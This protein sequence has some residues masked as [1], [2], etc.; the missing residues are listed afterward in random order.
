[1]DR[2]R[3]EVADHLS[4]PVHAVGDMRAAINSGWTRTLDV[5]TPEED[6]IILAYPN[7]RNEELS[8]RL[9]GRTAT[10]V[11]NRRVKI[12]EQKRSLHTYNPYA[13]AGRPLLAK[14]CTKCGR[15]LPG[16]WFGFGVSH[17]IKCYSSHCR[18]CSNKRISKWGKEAKRHQDG[19]ARAYQ[20]KAQAITLPLA[21]MKG[22]P[23]TEADHR[24]LADP[25][26][27]LLAKALITR[28]TYA[29]TS[30]AAQKAGYKSYQPIGDPERDR[31]LIDNPNACRVDEITA[32]LKQE[33]ES[34]GVKFPEWDWDDE[35][36]NG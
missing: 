15:I 20:E 11:S 29:G 3:R 30:G 32:A 1:M 28:R 5:W 4:R 25:S 23:W 31:W 24:V 17:G 16:K 33:F 22:Q 9:P 18:E 2:P 13:V 36:L 21:E 12:Q 8:A 6:A 34:A 7:F 19:R 10:A 14:T 26:L 27:T 35:D